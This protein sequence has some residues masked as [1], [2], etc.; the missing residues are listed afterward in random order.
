MAFYPC[1][2]AH[3]FCTFKIILVRNNLYFVKTIRF[4][5]SETD[6]NMISLIL[7]FEKK[8]IL[9]YLIYNIFCT[10]TLQSSPSRFRQPYYLKPFLTLTLG[11]TLAVLKPLLVLSLSVTLSL[12]V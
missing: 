9:Y 12:S 8:L 2:A 5:F 11:L 10:S 1:N 7:V 3:T 6:I 4:F